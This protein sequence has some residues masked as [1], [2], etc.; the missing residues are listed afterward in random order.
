MNV[1]TLNIALDQK[2]PAYEPI[3]ACHGAWTAGLGTAG[4]PCSQVDPALPADRVDRHRLRW[5]GTMSQ[6][7][8]GSCGSTSAPPPGSARPT[9]CSARGTAGP[10]A[11]PTWS[12]AF[13]ETHG[14]P[15]T[16]GAARRPGG[17]PAG[18]A[19]LPRHRAS[20]RWTS[21]R[22]SP[23]RPEI[24]LVDELAHT[25]VPGS[26]NAKRWQDVEELLDAGIDVITTV[27]IQ[28]LES[29]ND[30]VEKITG[31]PQRETVPDAVVRARRPGR[32][33]RHDAGGAAPPDG[34]RQRLPAGEDRRR[35][36]Q[37]LPGRQPDRAARAGPALAGRQGRRGPAALPRRRT[38]STAPG[39]PGS[40]SWSR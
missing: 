21:T 18:Q 33:G 9:R 16:A 7:G 34:A 4:D 6:D 40:G 36:D 30:V 23:A 22:C 32:A 2:Y 26:R 10:S 31:V 17:H 38:T 13:V 3:R 8:A 24:A 27:N 19:Q 14:R 37:L 1:L 5:H 35:A 11:A 20:R 12:S 15:H 28:H 25:N 39:R 29:L